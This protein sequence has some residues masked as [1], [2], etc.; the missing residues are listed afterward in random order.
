MHHKSIENLLQMLLFWV[1]MPFDSYAYSYKKTAAQV[2][3]SFFC[4]QHHCA[5]AR[6]AS[7]AV[8]MASLVMVEL[9]MASTP[10]VEPVCV[11]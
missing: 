9:V 6:Q 10:A 8:K 4:L 5:C 3:G 1:L 11:S 2:Y 7:M